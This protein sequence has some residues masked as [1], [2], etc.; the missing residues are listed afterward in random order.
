MMEERE[1]K[2]HL[3]NETLEIFYQSYEEQE[4]KILS[5]IAGIESPEDCLNR[6]LKLERKLQKVLTGANNCFCYGRYL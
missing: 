4:K 3:Y 6:K 2:L 1:K 5:N